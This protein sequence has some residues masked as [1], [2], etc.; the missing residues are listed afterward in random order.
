VQDHDNNPIRYYEGR[1]P[2][3]AVAVLSAALRLLTRRPRQSPAVDWRETAAEFGARFLVG[4]VIGAGLCVLL[5]PVIFWPS[6]RTTR[7][8]F[9][10]MGI[11]A[12]GI[13]LCVHA[14]GFVPYQRIPLVKYLIAMAGVALFIYGLFWPMAGR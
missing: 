12:L 1:P 7:S 10:Q 6:R 9:E 8:L 5:V 2:L 13:A 11:C 14:F 4:L 3:V